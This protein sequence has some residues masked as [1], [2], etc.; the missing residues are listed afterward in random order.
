MLALRRFAARRGFPSVIY[1]DN[2]KS[3]TGAQ[4]QLLKQFG[5]I[6]PQW[7]FISPRSPWWGGWWERL[8]RSVKAAL[9]KSVGIGTLTRTELETCLQE[10]EACVNSRPLTFVGDELDSGTP[11]TPSHFLIGRCAGFPPSGPTDLPV[12]TDQDLVSR[13]EISDQLMDQFWFVW[14]SHYLRMS[15]CLPGRV[16]QLRMSLG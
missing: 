1:S 15:F 14:K 8:V 12:V 16:L 7:R 3:F 9:R 2:S 11:L 6:C 5:H 10:I 4:T 13:K